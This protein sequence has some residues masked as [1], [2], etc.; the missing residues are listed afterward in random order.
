MW[1]FSELTSCR[2]QC[3]QL[4]IIFSIV[5]TSYFAN[6]VISVWNTLP[7]DRIDCTSFAAFKRTVQRIDFSTFLVRYW[8][9]VYTWVTVTVACG[10]MIQFTHVY[11]ST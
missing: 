5:R 8:E 10:F 4:F 2:G 9:Y 3:I 7:T 6:R 11:M 1:Q